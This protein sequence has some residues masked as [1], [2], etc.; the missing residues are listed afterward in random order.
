MRCLN[1]SLLPSHLPSFIG[2]GPLLR[3]VSSRYGRSSIIVSSNK[4]FSAW[5]EI[6]GDPVAVAALVDCLVH[7]ADVLVLRGDSH[8]LKGKELLQAD[9]G[10]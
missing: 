4:T 5:A 10:D 8:R 6:F 7:H 3:L 1:Q 2:I 9:A